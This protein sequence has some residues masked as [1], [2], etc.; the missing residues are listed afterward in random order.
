M[1]TT[2]GADGKD[3]SMSVPPVVEQLV[4]TDPAATTHANSPPPTAPTASARSAVAATSARPSWAR[5]QGSTRLSSSAG[6]TQQSGTSSA[7]S[8]SKVMTTVGLPYERWSRMGARRTRS[9]ARGAAAVACRR[10]EEGRGRTSCGVRAR[11]RPRGARWSRGEK[12]RRRWRRWAREQ[13][14]GHEARSCGCDVRAIADADRTKRGARGVA[15]RDAGVDA[16][17][18]RSSCA[19]RACAVE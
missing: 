11:P 1:A 15:I 19:V 10:G 13:A 9:G 17:A 8:M 2:F 4:C 18:A 7:R 12:Q 16:S 14:R 6:W 3:T 5:T